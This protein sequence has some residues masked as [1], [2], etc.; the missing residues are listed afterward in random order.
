[1][2]LEWNWLLLI[3][4][5]LGAISAAMIYLDMKNIGKVEVKWIVIC[6]L[7]SLIGFVLYYI[8]RERKPVKKPGQGRELP[9]KPDYGKPEY[10]FEEAGSVP[11][12]VAETPEVNIDPEP[13]PMVKEPVSIAAGPVL[14]APPTKES[15]VEP[16]PVEKPK[17]KIPQIEGIPRCSDCGAAI[18]IHDIKCPNCD[19]QLR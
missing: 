1:M 2:A 3:W 12:S 6:L 13:E 14:V 11:V 18:S 10:R 15:K 5:I 17:P 8:M 7:L 16:T 19:K 9:P 4:L